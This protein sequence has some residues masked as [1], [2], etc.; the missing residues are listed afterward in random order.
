MSSTLTSQSR[1]L[2]RYA[3]LAF[4]VIALIVAGALVAILQGGVVSFTILAVISFIV[5]STVVTIAVEGSRNGVNTLMQSL[6]YS[7]FLIA[8]VPLVSVLYST[9]AHGV[10]GLSWDFLTHSMYGVTGYYDKQAVANHTPILGGMFHA[11]MGTLLITLLT[12][13]IS[14][15]IGLLTS[16][17]LVEYA[18]GNHLSKIIVFL[19]DVMTGIPSIVAG[20]FS[21]AFFSLIIGPGTKNGA[22]GAVALSVL[23]IPVIVRSSEEMLR[24][25]PFELREASY[26]LGVPKWKTIL[27]VV[28]PTAISGIV[29]GV[30]IAIARVIGETA[31]LIVTAGFAL[32]M[33]YN[34]FHGWM[35][36]L[37][38]YIY[39]Q[40]L[41]PTAPQ[42]PEPSLE[43][44]WAAALILIVIVMLLN[45]VAR[46]IA[47]YFA[48][49]TGK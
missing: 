6:I 15:P 38:A 44:A 48:P 4:V 47:R 40:A 42:A 2:P 25:V 8:L 29:S 1:R 43:R 20:L 17:Y 41:N 16:I 26:A 45:L 24:L 22:V 3:P 33:N 7:A 5:I 39:Q 18:E 23:M 14:V 27:K 36:A 11:L 35:T 46:L 12:T 21:Y 30:T 31:P 28:L 37:P 34:L 10:P 9:I 32:K 13:L 19:V 49:K